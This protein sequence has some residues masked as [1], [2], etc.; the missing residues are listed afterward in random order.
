MGF[1][2]LQTSSAM[3]STCTYIFHHISNLFPAGWVLSIHALSGQPIYQG[4]LLLSRG[5]EAVVRRG[6]SKNSSPLAL[7]QNDKMYLYLWSMTCERE[8]KLLRQVVEVQC[9]IHHQ[10]DWFRIGYPGEKPTGTGPDGDI[11]S[12]FLWSS[13]VKAVAVQG[14]GDRT[15]TAVTGNKW[16]LCTSNDIITDAC[17]KWLRH[18]GDWE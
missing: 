7:P 14:C 2:H 10:G 18:L 13:R 11:L 3:V 15:T 4:P 8:S 12:W 1:Q 9:P 16:C 5:W 6:H 17:M